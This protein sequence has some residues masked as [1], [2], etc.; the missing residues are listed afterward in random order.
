MNS[1]SYV[2]LGRIAQNLGFLLQLAFML[3]SKT[4]KVNGIAFLLIAIGLFLTYFTERSTKIDIE[5][6]LRISGMSLCLII[7]I[8]S[9]YSSKL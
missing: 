7:A 5:N 6:I 9:I 8:V 4:M 1:I 3:Y 2:L